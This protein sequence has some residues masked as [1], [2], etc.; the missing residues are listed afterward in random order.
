MFKT[1]LL[2]LF[3]NYILKYF[4]FEYL[5]FY[6]ICIHIFSS[7]NQFNLPNHFKYFRLF[8]DSLLLTHLFYDK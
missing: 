8:A 7:Y 2:S 4:K 5:I 1:F 6:Y 3:I